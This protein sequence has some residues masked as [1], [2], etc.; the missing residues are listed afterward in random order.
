M[1]KIVL[2]M[3]YLLGL[4]III[5]IAVGCKHS[6]DH[7][8]P[9]PHDHDHPHDHPH[10]HPHED[11]KDGK[12]MKAKQQFTYLTMNG[13]FI[14]SP[15]DEKTENDP[16]NPS[17]LIMSTSSEAGTLTKIK[18]YDHKDVNK[19]LANCG[20]Q[21]IGSKPDP[22]YFPSKSKTSIWDIFEKVENYEGDCASYKYVLSRSPHD[23]PVHMHLRY[24]D[25]VEVLL[26]MSKDEEDK[27]NFN[28]WWATYCGVNQP[29]AC[30]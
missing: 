22:H 1:N 4:F 2:N 3:K 12:K 18:F 17:R 21:F 14:M 15:G 5:S 25:N 19:M 20:Y 23:V 8:H 7:P 27:A 10:P 24:G 9:H 13:E 30:K 6:H 28:P 29:N 16:R 11:G 26:N